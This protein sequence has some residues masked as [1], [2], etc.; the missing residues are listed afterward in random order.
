MSLAG[1]ILLLMDHRHNQK[2]NL[3]G[4]TTRAAKV[5]AQL[6]TT[7][8]QYVPNEA[9]QNTSSSSALCHLYRRHNH[10]NHK[11]A[12]PTKST[13]DSLTMQRVTVWSRLVIIQIVDISDRPVALAS[14]LL[15]QHGLLCLEHIKRHLH[16]FPP[17]LLRVDLIQGDKKGKTRGIKKV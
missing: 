15:L 7:Y 8:R 2:Q 14:F 6:M 17:L 10:N 9:I 13:R 16:L 1:H 5:R 11:W 12:F 3:H 4:G